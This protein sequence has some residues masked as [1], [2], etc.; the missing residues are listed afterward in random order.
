VAH[1]VIV[2]LAV[3]VVFLGLGAWRFSRIEI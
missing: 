3:G 1:D 2:L